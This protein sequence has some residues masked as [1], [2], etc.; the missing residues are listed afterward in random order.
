MVKHL[1]TQ[2]FKQN[3]ADFLPLFSVVVLAVKKSGAARW[4]CQR[5]LWWRRRSSK[6]PPRHRPQHAKIQQQDYGRIFN[7]GK[8]NKQDMAV[9]LG[10]HENRVVTLFLPLLWILCGNINMFMYITRNK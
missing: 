5:R 1:K 6:V 9:K 3:H 4:W 7:G 10:R 2:I 8:L